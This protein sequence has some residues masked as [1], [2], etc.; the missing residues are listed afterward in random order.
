MS[1]V[2]SKLTSAIYPGTLMH[3]RISPKKHQFSYKVASWLLDLDELRDI[4]RRHWLFSRNRFNLIAFYDK[5]YGDGSGHCL[6]QQVNDL[7]NS[8]HIESAEQ[9]LLFC[10]PRVLGY[11]FNPLSVYFCLRSGQLIAVVYEVSNTFGERHSYVIEAEQIKNEK[12]TI[13]QM[14]NKK[15][16]VSPFFPMDCFYRFRTSIPSEEVALSISLHSHHPLSEKNQKVF[17]AVFKGAR[18]SISDKS[19]LKLALALPLQTFK[20]VA[21]IHWEAL[22][23]WLKGIRLY[24]HK[25]AKQRFSWSKGHSISLIK[26]DKELS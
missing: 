19:T 2:L 15:L 17:A 13:R 7:L 8:N 11:V 18:Q 25:P 10:Y 9:V 16:H 4:D 24:H 6:K 21:A 14:A 12:T 5:D 20:V 23:I 26:A 22:R 1:K 3:N